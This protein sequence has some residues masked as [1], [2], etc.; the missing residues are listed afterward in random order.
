LKIGIAYDFTMQALKNKGTFTSWSD[1]GNV[2]NVN[3]NNRSVG[4]VE[5]YIG[6]CIIPP[7]KPDFDIYT[8][9]LFL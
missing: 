5:L 4:S 7:P 1:A 8:D 6:Y 2:Q 3:T 9:P